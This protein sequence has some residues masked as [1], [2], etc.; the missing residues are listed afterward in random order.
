MF[1]EFE[2][3]FFA[4]SIFLRA[5]HA[6]ICHFDMPSGLAPCLFEKQYTEACSL[7]VP[8]IKEL[9]TLQSI[10]MIFFSS[11]PYAYIKVVR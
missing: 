7:S 11:G 5:Q 3:C 9:N 1:L 4:F 10:I 8:N 6:S 2:K